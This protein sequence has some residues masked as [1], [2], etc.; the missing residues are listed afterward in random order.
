MTEPISKDLISIN[1]GLLQNRLETTSQ[2]T[3][4]VYKQPQSKAYLKKL[5]QSSMITP[6]NSAVL[7]LSNYLF[8]DDAEWVKTIKNAKMPILFIGPSNSEKLYKETKLEVKINYEIIPESGHVVFVDNPLE[9][10]K[11]LENF[12]SKK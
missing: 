2:F 12:L 8:N 3:R 7:L 5:I 10:N 1:K 6:T 9:F 11:I 4:G